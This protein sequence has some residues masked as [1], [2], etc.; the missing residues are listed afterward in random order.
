MSHFL[1]CRYCNHLFEIDQKR[2]EKGAVGCEECGRWFMVSP[3][4]LIQ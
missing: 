3:E 2:L 4:I 1:R